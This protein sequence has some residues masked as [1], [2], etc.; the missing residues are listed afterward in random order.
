VDLTGINSRLAALEASNKAILS[1]M[2][3]ISSAVVR[4]ITFQVTKSDGTTSS[5]AAQ[6]GGTISLSTVD[7][8]LVKRIS[9]IEARLS[10]LTGGK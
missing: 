5:A 8:A 2:D 6:L 4:P 1:T 3:K 9:A 10:T 7:D